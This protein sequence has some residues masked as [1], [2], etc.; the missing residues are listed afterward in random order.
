MQEIE[1]ILPEWIRRQAYLLSS[2]QV[3]VDGKPT[4]E[5]HF[6]YLLTAYCP[7]IFESYAIVLN[8]FWVNWKA[9]TLDYSDQINNQQFNGKNNISSGSKIEKDRYDDYERLNW[10]KLFEYFGYDFDLR[11][12]YQIYC[13]ISKKQYKIALD[14]KKR[15]NDWP[16]LLFP[17]D[18]RC[19]REEL[20]F[21]FSKLINLY[22]DIKANFFYHR[23]IMDG[24][25]FKN[26]LSSEFKKPVV[27]GLHGNPSSVFP[28]DKTWC[29]VSN[30]DLDFSYIGGTKEFIESIASNNEFDIYEIK[31]IFKE[32]C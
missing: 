1:N 29:I 14:V 22:G 25:I 16:W 31:P 13:I 21:I 4:R 9:R 30:Y 26:K 32:K 19:E 11:T 2:S 27:H 12:A 18:G 28:D 23:H 15:N 10:S 20:K 7:L 17:N 3:Q 24:E 8:P 6:W 5:N